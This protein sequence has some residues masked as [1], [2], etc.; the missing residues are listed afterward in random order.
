MKKVEMPDFHPS[1]KNLQ[2]QV[3]RQ[4]FLKK[5]FR[6]THSSPSHVPPIL[7]W[8]LVKPEK[9]KLPQCSLVCGW[10]RKEDAFSYFNK[11]LHP[12]STKGSLRDRD[13]EQN[14]LLRGDTCQVLME[15]TDLYTE[16]YSPWILLQ[17]DT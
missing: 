15:V 6:G 13:P 8:I 10:Q 11:V 12:S 7:A 14:T 9:E 1:F 3:K 4:Q 5:Q 17:A 2:A 16:L